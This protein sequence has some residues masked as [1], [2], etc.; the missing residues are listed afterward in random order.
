MAP[1]TKTRVL[2]FV[3]AAIANVIAAPLYLMPI[4]TYL[5]SNA[6]VLFAAIGVLVAIPA[7]AWA[8][9]R[10]RRLGAAIQLAML[11]DPMIRIVMDPRGD[12]AWHRWSDF[13]D[14]R[15]VL[16]LAFFL[17][18]AALIALSVV[19]LHVKVRGR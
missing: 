19:S 2:V 13:A 7:V 17:V 5:H 14:F 18:P 10:S 8:W 9:S 3:A 11:A 16:A 1:S 12:S 15:F 4:L 6:A